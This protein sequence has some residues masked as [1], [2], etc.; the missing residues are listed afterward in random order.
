MAYVRIFQ[1][2]GVT[3]DIYDRINA[4]MG[5]EDQPPAGLLFHCAGEVDG[6]WQIIDAWESEGHAQRFDD[7]QLNAAIEKVTGMRPPGPPPGAQ[8]YELHNV[9]KP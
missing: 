2:P 7:E 5:V 6:K 9:I 3:P 4:E 1:P 8:G